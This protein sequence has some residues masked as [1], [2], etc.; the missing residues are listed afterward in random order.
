LA[1]RLLQ[2]GKY[3]SICDAVAASLDLW[4]LAKHDLNNYVLKAAQKGRL[5]SKGLDDCIEFCHQLDF[6]D[7]V[8]Y[9]ENGELKAKRQSFSVK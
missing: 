6:T 3:E 2:S 5:A 8:P 4:S 7:L 1:E 9:F